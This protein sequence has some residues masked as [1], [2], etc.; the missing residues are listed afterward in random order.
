MKALSALLI[1]SVAASIATGCSHAK[2]YR[3]HRS[4]LFNQW[5]K[6]DSP[7]RRPSQNSEA[8]EADIDALARKVIGQ[9]RPPL[10]NV[11]VTSPFGQRGD[12]FHEGVDLRAKSGTP[13]YAAGAG[14]VLYAGKRIRG[15]G[16]M[17]VIKHASGLS[18]VYAH[19]SKLM[20][21]QGQRVKIGQRIATSGATGHVRG[22]H[23][24]FEVRNGVRAIDPMLL[25]P[26]TQ[27]TAFREDPKA[28]AVQN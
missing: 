9:F 5:S 12:E 18:T 7:N 27:N 4:G 25:Y 28:V 16:K 13:V 1:F 20:V 2:P 17:I 10:Q 8:E 23:L 26:N 6:L 3:S 22:P 24:H 15:Y 21:R 11:E 19:N 14:Q